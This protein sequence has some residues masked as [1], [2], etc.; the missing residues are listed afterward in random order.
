MW[1]LL[2]LVVMLMN[3]VA[4]VE[5]THTI[6][7]HPDYHMHW[8]FDEDTITVKLVVNTTGYLTPIFTVSYKIDVRPK[9]V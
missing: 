3:V 8:K 2:M 9:C 4:S 7:L 6:Q 1:K 5:F